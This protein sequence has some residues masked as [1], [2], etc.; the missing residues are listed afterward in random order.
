MAVCELGEAES[1]VVFG[2]LRTG[3]REGIAEVTTRK[4]AHLVARRLCAISGIDEAK[5]I[6]IC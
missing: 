5:V 1:F 3:G 6:D 4:I 2:H